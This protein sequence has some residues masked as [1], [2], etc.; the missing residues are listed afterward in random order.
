MGGGPWAGAAGLRAMTRM[1]ASG[2]PPR[3]VSIRAATE[4][5][6][7]AV[8]AIEGRVFPDPWTRGAFE[9]LRG[10]PRVFFRVA[11]G[12][13]NEVVGYVVLW[14]VLDEGEVANVAVAPERRREGIGHALMDAAVG[15]AR[16]AGVRQLFLEVRA[17]NAAARAMY[18]SRG[19]VQI[20]RRRDYY[21]KPVEDALVLRLELPAEGT[22]TVTLSTAQGK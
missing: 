13:A 16:G 20:S 12:A 10:N 22:A 7:T 3:A 1:R 19:F 8:A 15:A 4:D 11:A 9:A 18:Q 17:S 5:D 2:T 6:I 14:F 21:R